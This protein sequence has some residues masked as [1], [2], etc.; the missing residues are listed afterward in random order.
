MACSILP[1]MGAGDFFR[2]EGLRARVAWTMARDGLTVV[3][4]LDGELLATKPPLVYWLVALPA[5]W[6]GDLPL[7]LA[8]W[9]SV[10]AFILLTVGFSL[11]VR[12]RHGARAGLWAGLL[13]PMAIGWLAQVPS[14]E[15]DM[16]LVA[17]VAAAWMALAV[18]LSGEAGPGTRWKWWLAAGAMA[19]LGFWAK[20]TAP[21]FLHAAVVG[22][23]L[24]RRDRGVLLGPGHGLAITAEAGLCLAWLALAGNEVGFQPLVDGI[25]RRE[26]LPHLSPWHHRI[27]WQPLDC[28]TYPI[29]VL[30]MGLPM[31]LCLALWFR[32]DLRR[33]VGNDSFFQVVVA[34]ALV[35]LVFW[36]LVPGHRPR[37]SLPSLAGLVLAGAWLGSLAVGKGQVPGRATIWARVACVGW[38]LAL[39]GTQFARYQAGNAATAPRATA[40]RMARV[41]PAGAT[42][43]VA[44]IRDDGLLLQLERRGFRVIRASKPG[45]EATHWLIPTEMAGEHPIALPGNWTDQQG[46]GIVLMGR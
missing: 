31:V 40:E 14:A 8:R 41:L 45:P 12:S 20:W 15:L 33:D 30:G 38:V 21:V 3:P 19:G 11:L 44:G 37:H 5:R 13:F 35:S 1:G 26:A 36:T 10:A 34:G 28:I 2:N 18:A 25:I 4:R 46:G 6:W 23:A 24:L 29:Q 9:P 17:F 43:G 42:L 7:P 32:G 16:P 22:M 27:G 39:L